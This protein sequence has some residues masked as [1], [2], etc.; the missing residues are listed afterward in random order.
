MPMTME[1]NEI[2]TDLIAELELLEKTESG[3]ILEKGVCEENIR[4]TVPLL[5]TVTKTM[6]GYTENHVRIMSQLDM[7]AERKTIILSII[8]K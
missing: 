5:N 4:K 3:L 7:I 1:H 2:L 8:E 6:N